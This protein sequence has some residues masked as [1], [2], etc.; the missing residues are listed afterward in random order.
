MLKKSIPILI[1]VLMI[2]VFILQANFALADCE[3]ICGDNARTNKGPVADEN[4]CHDLCS[5][6]GI[7][8]KP[9]TQNANN[10]NNKGNTPSAKL[11]NPIG[12][13]YI[14]DI[15]SR[16]IKI[17]LG[18][19]GTVSLIVFIYAG[20]LWITAQGKPDQINKGRQAM[21]WAV[22]GIVVVFSSYAILRY[23]FEI[24]SF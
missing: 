23:V 16:I 22:V 19:V 4:K 12:I 18:L 7:D 20:F 1:L 15:I 10:N 9:I 2:F 6:Y 21:L 17:I 14:P 13:S 11:D 5:P 3:C 24:L 8:C